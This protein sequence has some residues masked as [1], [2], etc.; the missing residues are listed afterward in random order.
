LARCSHFDG[1]TYVCKDADFKTE[2]VYLKEKVDAGA[3]KIDTSHKDNTIA[4]KIAFSH[5]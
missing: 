5:R 1:K 4:A 3:G 2:M